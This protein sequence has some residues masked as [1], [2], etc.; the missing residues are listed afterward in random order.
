MDTGNAASRTW[1][2]IQELWNQLEQTSPNSPEYDELLTEIRALS[3]EYQTLTG[4]SNAPRS[5]GTG[6]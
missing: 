4:T 2:R 5:K 3:I 6:G 1:Q